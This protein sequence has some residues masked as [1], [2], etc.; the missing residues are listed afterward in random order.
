MTTIQEAM[1][2]SEQSLEVEELP[3]EQ[4]DQ[5]EEREK[6]DAEEP[7]LG[8][9]EARAGGAPPWVVLPPDLRFPR[10]VQAIFMRFPSSWTSAPHK[11]EP[12]EGEEGLWRQCICWEINVGDKKL[13]LQRAQ[14]DPNRVIDEMTK[15]MI[16]AVDGHKCSWEGTPGP[17]NIEVW[18]S[19]VGERVR[20]LMNKVFLQTHQLGREETK[21]FFESCIA[22]RTTGA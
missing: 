4:G 20:S 16:R 10:G 17:G 14:S 15:Q 9:P 7:A 1:E 19:E 5:E 3:L 11:G 18:W 6:K 22:V 21:R 12:I 13:S 2:P 8:V